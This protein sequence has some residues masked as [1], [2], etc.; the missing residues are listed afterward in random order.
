MKW[1]LPIAFEMFEES[2]LS[3][4]GHEEDGIQLIKIKDQ[5]KEE[6]SSFALSNFS[7]YDSHL[8]ISLFL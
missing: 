1:Q 7:K 8:V 6:D 3:L 5:L 2:L 4:R